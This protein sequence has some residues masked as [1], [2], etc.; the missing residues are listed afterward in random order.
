MNGCHRRIVEVRRSDG[1]F[2][3]ARTDLDGF[4]EQMSNATTAGNGLALVIDDQKFTSVPLTL[5]LRIGHEVNL[6]GQSW[7]PEIYAEYTHEFDNDNQ[8]VVGHFVSDP[9]KTRFVLPT[10]ETDRDYMTVGVQA[11]TAFSEGGAAYLLYETLL[12]HRYL[13]VHSFEA[14]LRFQF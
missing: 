3:W 11:S 10:D 13:N 9:S 4:Q 6:A 7:L 5:G 8:P 1:R 12:F 14:G 2:E